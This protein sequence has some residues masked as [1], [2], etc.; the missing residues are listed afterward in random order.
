[1]QDRHA[2]DE[3]TGSRST[4]IV[5]KSGAVLASG[6][7]Q[8]STGRTG[9]SRGV[10]ACRF[11][12]RAELITSNPRLAPRENGPR[13]FDVP[14]MADGSAESATLLRVGPVRLFD[15][16]TRMERSHS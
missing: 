8:A 6:H 10:P 4:R 12:D 2:G 16:A 3:A 14:T 7:D 9:V 5:R 15:A 11:R 1:M 13:D